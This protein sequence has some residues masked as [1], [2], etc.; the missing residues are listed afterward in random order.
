VSQSIEHSAPD[1]ER[2]VGRIRDD[3]FGET[4]NG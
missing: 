2:L 3:V 4:K 1:F